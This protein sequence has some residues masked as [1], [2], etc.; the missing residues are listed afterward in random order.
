MG[1]TVP[2]A[3]IAVAL[4]RFDS[5]SRVSCACVPEPW[6]SPADPRRIDCS[7]FV[8]QAPPI[9]HP[10]A[11]RSRFSR[12]KTASV[13]RLATARGFGAPARLQAAP[14]HCKPPLTLT[15]R[16]HLGG[17][18]ERDP[19]GMGLRVWSKDHGQSVF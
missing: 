14:S 4:G 18:R 6:K 3:G 11:A 15:F 12:L 9:T 2:K 19:G 13:V 16:L 17:R 7:A 8:L 5:L 1:S 10:H